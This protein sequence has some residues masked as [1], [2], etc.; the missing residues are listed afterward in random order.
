MTTLH[1][2]N[3]RGETIVGILEKKPED[4]GE[5]PRLVLIAHG[6]LGKT[7]LER[8]TDAL[9]CPPQLTLMQATRTICF[10]HC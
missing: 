7:S 10:S 6:V 8:S 4:I 1:I 2:K 3:A 5:R 9:Q